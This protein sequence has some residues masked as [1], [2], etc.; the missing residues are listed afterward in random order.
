VELRPIDLATVRIFGIEGVSETEED[1]KTTGLKR[2]VAVVDAGHG[3]GVVVDGQGIVLTAKHVVEHAEIL[4]VKVPGDERVYAARTIYMDP[5][6]DIAF[7]VLDGHPAHYLKLPEHVKPM[8]AGQH[9]SASGYPLDPNQSTPAL[10]S[11][12][13]SRRREDGRYQLDMSV[14]PGN[15][16]GPVT[17]DHGDLLGIVVQGADPTQGA[18]GM[19]I[20]EPLQLIRDAY[21]GGLTSAA[22]SHEFTESDAAVAAAAYELVRSGPFGIVEDPAVHDKLAGLG[23]SKRPAVLALMAGHTWNMLMGLLEQRS[24]AKVDDLTNADDKKNAVQLLGD[25]I[26][27]CRAA[28]GVDPTLE[29]RSAFVKDVLAAA[30]QWQHEAQVA[31]ESTTSGLVPG[32]PSD[33]ALD[34]PPP[35]RP[36]IGIDLLA[37]DTGDGVAGGLAVVGDVVRVARDHLAVAVG[38]EGT[39]GTWRGSIA[40]DAAADL[41]LRASAGGHVGVVG[42]AFYTPGYVSAEGRSMLTFRSYRAMGGVYVGPVTVG[43][44]WQEVGRGADDTLRTFGGYLELG[45]F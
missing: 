3:S 31:K 33:R 24:V 9:V 45:C 2:M 32:A 15:S 7:V 20:A 4:A 23:P 22:R 27:L 19:A 43:V 30:A 17:N 40:A 10:S 8:R 6:H 11:G 35:R 37:L 5:D 41:G 42:G 28:A 21:A 16:G 13:M 38:G 39:L 14:N 12:H 36:A 34:A 29:D 44:A 25:T 26:R 1:G 18:Q